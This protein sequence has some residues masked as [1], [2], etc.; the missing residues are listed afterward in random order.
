VTFSY[1]Y[2]LLHNRLMGLCRQLVEQCEANPE[3]SDCGVTALGAIVLA[4][5][6]VEI[7]TNNRIEKSLPPRDI[8]PPLR[9]WVR[10]TRRQLYRRPLLIRLEEIGRIL[11]VIVDLKQPPWRA[12]RQLR[13]VRNVLVHYEAG[14]LSS[15]HPDTD[16]FPQRG[17][18]EP[19]AKELG[20]LEGATTWLE[21]FLNP[22]CA[23]W[24]YDTADKALHELDTGP[25]N[26]HLRF[27][28]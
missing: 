7:A 20:T 21:A 12:V 9:A 19:F 14:P 28:G 15:T 16:L 22:T 1:H 6:C 23:R 17:T 27:D 4:A 25:L 24:A 3:G 18:L 5:T 10:F 2:T 11:G 26:L 13:D 8:V